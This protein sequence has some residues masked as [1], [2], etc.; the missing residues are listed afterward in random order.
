MPIVIGIDPGVNNLGL[1]AI[2]DDGDVMV[3]KM[4]FQAEGDPNT[5]VS[6]Y[7]RC[8]DLRES[9]KDWLGAVL[10]FVGRKIITSDGQCINAPIITVEG[11]AFA[12]GGTK[13]I[14]VGFLHSAIYEAVACQRYAT[15]VVIPPKTLKKYVANN[16]NAGKE[17]MMECILRRWF[18][19]DIPDFGSQDLYEAY[20]LGR[21]GQLVATGDCPEWLAKACRVYIVQRGRISEVLDAE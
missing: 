16:G 11:P 5:A 18:K 20:A 15:L 14:Q 9:L 3:Q 7:L 12:R 6:D 17:K 21:V 2:T 10:P 1:A 8:L 19:R 4:G 13:S